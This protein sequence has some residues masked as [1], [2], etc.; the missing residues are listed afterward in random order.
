[1]FVKLHSIEKKSFQLKNTTFQLNK[2]LEFEKPSNCETNLKFEKKTVT[3][4]K[5]K[6]G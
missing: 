3:N 1:M 4:W 5:S 2:T 6:I